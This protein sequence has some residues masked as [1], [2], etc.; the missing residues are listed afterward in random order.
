MLA[1]ESDFS[2]AR[3]GEYL[4]EPFRTWFLVVNE[5]EFNVV[6]TFADLRVSGFFFFLASVK[7]RVLTAVYD[8][9]RRRGRADHRWLDEDFRA[10]AAVGRLR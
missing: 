1:Q 6:R 4:F 9:G 8:V 10:V 5:M 3:F 2:E 7:E